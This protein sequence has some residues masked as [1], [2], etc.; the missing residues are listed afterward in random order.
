MTPTVSFLTRPLSATAEATGRIAYEVRGEGPLVVTAPGMGDLRS[1]DT[2]LAEA[3]VADG[4]RVATLDLRTVECDLPGAELGE[5]LEGHF[6]LLTGAWVGI[7]FCPSDKGQNSRVLV[8]ELSEL[9]QVSPPTDR[10]RPLDG[11]RQGSPSPQVE[12]ALPLELPI[13]SNVARERGKQSHS[14]EPARFTRAAEWQ[15]D[16]SA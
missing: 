9:I 13:R 5:V 2:A 8:C 16:R 1:A 7:A 14:T 6:Q 12:L 3:L 10:L 11:C 15:S 4:F